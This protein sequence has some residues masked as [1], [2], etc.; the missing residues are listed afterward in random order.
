[1]LI[2]SISP[3]E[4]L[5]LLSGVLAVITINLLILYLKRYLTA[6]KFDVGYGEKQHLSIPIIMTSIIV[7]FGISILAKLG[8]SS[9]Q[10]LALQVLSVLVIT[11]TWCDVKVGLILNILSIPLIIFGIIA[12]FLT[13]WTTPIMALGG[14]L[15]GYGFYALIHW[16][17]KCTTKKNVLGLGDAKYMAGLGAFF[18]IQGVLIIMIVTSLSAL[19]ISP[20]VFNNNQQQVKA[21]KPLAPFIALGI[22]V[23]L[24]L[25]IF[26]SSSFI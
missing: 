12:S 5:L 10:V 19:I 22:I 2:N 20:F 26:I 15:I 11:I 24:F 18:G 21:F 9:L 16:V 14:L 25:H 17:G 7:L 4:P 6:S 3:L 13:T 8:L 1:M 23:Y